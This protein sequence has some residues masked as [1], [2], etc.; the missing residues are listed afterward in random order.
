MGRDGTGQEAGLGQRLE[1][2]LV[3]LK[4]QKVEVYCFMECSLFSCRC[5]HSGGRESSYQVGGILQ[6]GAGDKQ[7]EDTLLSSVSG[8]TMTNQD[9]NQK[10]TQRCFKCCAGMYETWKKRSQELVKFLVKVGLI[11]FVLSSLLKFKCDSSVL[12]A[13]TSQSCKTTITTQT[14]LPLALYQ[15]MSL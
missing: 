11:N 10:A 5:V 12:T 7:L 13:V 4:G 14:A 3:C 9:C 2:Q 8:A 1:S 15:P 6:G